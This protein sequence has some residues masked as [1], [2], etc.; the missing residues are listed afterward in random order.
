VRMGMVAVFAVCVIVRRSVCSGVIVQSAR[1]MIVGSLVR[2]SVKTGEQYRRC[3]IQAQ[4]QHRPARRPLCFG[5]QQT[6][7]SWLGHVRRRL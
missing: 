5:S 6:Y 7:E 3:Q 1:M 4:Q 2:R